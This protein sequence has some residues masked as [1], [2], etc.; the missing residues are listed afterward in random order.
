MVYRLQPILL[1]Y[2]MIPK[3][4]VYMAVG[5]DQRYR[6]KSFFLYESEETVLLSTVDHP[7]IHYDAAAIIGREQVGILLEWIEGEAVYLHSIGLG[8]KTIQALLA[9]VIFTNPALTR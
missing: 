5:I 8:H 1:V 4:V 9:V 7:R 6:L 2:R 3:Y